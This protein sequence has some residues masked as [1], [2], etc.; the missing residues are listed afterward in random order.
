[1]LLA[2]NKRTLTEGSSPLFTAG[3]KLGTVEMVLLW[4]LLQ[5]DPACP[6]RVLLDRVAQTQRPMAVSI[7]HLNRLRATWA[8]SRRKGRPR[9]VPYSPP[10]A[11]DAAIVQI[12]PRLAFVGVHLFAHWLDQHDT[13]SPVVAQL[14]QAIE[15]HKRTH[16][17][18][19]FALLHHRAQTLRHRFQALFFAPLFGIKHLTEF[20]TREHP[21][22]TLL[23]RSYQSS[24]LTQ[25]LGQLERVRADEASCPR[26][27]QPKLARSRI[28]MGI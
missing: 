3:R 11:S 5:K 23:G 26:W 1:M 15:A 19:D 25:F 13:F 7:R 22:A 27:Y 20:D 12:T 8:L 17:D 18:D 14:T 4:Q 24:T 21:L 28:L 6:S 2:P 10:V 9:Q 16:P